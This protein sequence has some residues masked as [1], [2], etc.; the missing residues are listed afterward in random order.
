MRDIEA[1]V[2]DVGGVLLLPDP[3]AVGAALRSADVDH[4]TDSLSAA[5]YGGVAALDAAPQDWQFGGAPSPYVRGLLVAAGV[6]EDDLD[7]AAAALVPVFARPSI[8]VWSHETPWARA[9]LRRLAESA[10]P[11]ALVSN[12]DGTVEAQMHLHGF[13]QVGRGQGLDVAAIVDSGVHGV[14][15]PDPRIFDPALDALGVA[16]ERCAYVGDTVSYDVLGAR[17]AGLVPIHLDPFGSCRD[18]DHPH[19]RTLDQAVDLALTA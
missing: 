1:I 14:S 9:G 2:L 5:H 13:A 11:T 18:D 4:D 8:E 3:A 15:K 7:R 17:N 12:A 10:T 16:A 6:A 19:A